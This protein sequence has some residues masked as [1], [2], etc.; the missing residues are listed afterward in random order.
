MSNQHLAYIAIV[1]CIEIKS[2]KFD[3]ILCMVEL[4]HIQTLLI[5]MIIFKLVKVK[6]GHYFFNLVDFYSLIAKKGLYFINLVA[7]TN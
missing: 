1:I 3:H 2:V 5:I 6:K 7:F 4:V